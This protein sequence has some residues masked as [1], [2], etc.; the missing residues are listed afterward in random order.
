MDMLLFELFNSISETKNFTRTA[1]LFNISQ[2]AVTHNIKKLEA[3]VGAPLINRTRHGIEFTA[4]GKEYLTFVQQILSTMSNAEMRINNLLEGKYGRV[5]IASVPTTVRLLLEDLEYARDVISG[6]D[7]Q[8]DVE[9]YDGPDM[10]STFVSDNYDF[11][12]TTRDQVESQ[13]QFDFIEI[14]RGSLVLF[15]NMEY[16][17]K[18]EKHHTDAFENAPLLSL[19]L[20]HR[21]LANPIKRLS[22]INDLPFNNIHYYKRTESV[23][24]AVSAG[25]G[26]AILPDTITEFYHYPELRAMPLDGGDDCLSYVFA[27]KKQPDSNAVNS[28]RDAIIKRY[29]GPQA[30]DH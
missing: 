24:I 14:S 6:L 2:P 10:F 15:M 12:Y 3:E 23:L 27:W 8:I 20:I 7:L 21:H 16:C 11:Y 26:L 5:R 25:L 28:V 1:E 17:E 22:D 13:E 29:T 18:Y 19:P 30:G 9:V 4:A